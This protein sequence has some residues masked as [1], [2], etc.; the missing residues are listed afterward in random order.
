[1][2]EIVVIL[3]KSIIIGALIGF[4]LGAGAARMFHIPKSQSLGAFRT[5]GE[6]NA[7]QGDRASHFSFGIGFLFYAWASAVGAGALT[8]NVGHR[9]IP[10][11]SVA[12]LL[13]KGKT[14]EETMHNPLKMSIAGTIVGTV[15]VAFLSITTASIPGGLK[16]VATEVLIPAAEWLLNPVMPAIFWLAA[17]DAGKRTGFWGTILGG[18]A[19]IIMGNAIPGIVLGILVGKGVEDNGWNKITKTLLSAII[20]MFILIAFFKEVDIDFLESINLPV[21]GWLE[22]LHSMT[23]DE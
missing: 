18:P 10:N 23:S 6:M 20:I 3:F 5:I 13:R 7:C 1:M 17:L 9:I 11:W 21:P 8:Q 16:S 4:P 15:I 12:L 2:S 19:H 14:V 22:S